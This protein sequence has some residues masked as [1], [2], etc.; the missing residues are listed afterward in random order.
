LFR[1]DADD[2]AVGR[3][4]VNPSPLFTVEDES[5]LLAL[6]RLVA[7]AKFA[8]HPD[9]KDLWGSPLVNALSKRLGEALREAA[10]KSPTPGETERHDAWVE[11]LRNNVVLAVVKQRLKEDAQSA[12]WRAFTFVEKAGYVRDC[13]SPF[14]ADDVLVKELIEEAEA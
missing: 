7:E 2:I 6:W 13:I 5:E 11:S 4:V 12:Q 10:R 9:D 1:S 14:L 8:E 3:T